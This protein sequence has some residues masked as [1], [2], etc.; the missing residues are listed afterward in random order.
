MSI[1]SRWRLRTN[2]NCLF[3]DNISHGKI[4]LQHNARPNLRPYIH[5]LKLADGSVCLT[6]DSP[7]HH[8][9]QHGVQTGFH[10]VNG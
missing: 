1:D 7:W 9:W 4:I 8:P 5:P 2:N 3:V 10:G 6:E